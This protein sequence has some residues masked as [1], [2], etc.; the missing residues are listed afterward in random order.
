MTQ[1]HLVGQ[2][3]SI[4]RRNLK[5]SQE[6][7]AGKVGVTQNYI[8]QIETGRKFPSFTLLGE[9]ADALG[10]SVATLVE[11]DPIASDVRR[12]VDQN[13]LDAVL[14]TVSQLR[15]Q[16]AGQATRSGGSKRRTRKRKSVRSH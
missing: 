2:Q 12:L 14:A 3:V 4:L 11:D 16:S 1:K 5:L 10:V 8:C 15:G 13:G 6:T 9:I 7:L